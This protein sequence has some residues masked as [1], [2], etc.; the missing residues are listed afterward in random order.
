MIWKAFYAHN[1]APRTFDMKAS[2]R[3]AKR[4][5]SHLFAEGPAV[6]FGEWE[7]IVDADPDYLFQRET[8]RGGLV[9]TTLNAQDLRYHLDIP[10]GL[11]YTEYRQWF[12]HDDDIE[13]VFADNYFNIPDDRPHDR[14][15]FSSDLTDDPMPPRTYFPERSNIQDNE[16]INPAPEPMLTEQAWNQILFEFYFNIRG[17]HWTPNWTPPDIT[18]SQREFILTIASRMK[19]EKPQKRETLAMAVCR[20]IREALD[21]KS[22]GEIAEI[23]GKSRKFMYDLM[24]KFG[25]KA[26]DSPHF[27]MSENRKQAYAKRKTEHDPQR[28]AIQDLYSQGYAIDEIVEKTG[29]SRAHVG[30]ATSLMDK[31]KNCPNC[32]RNFRA[33]RVSQICCSQPCYKQYSK[34]HPNRRNRRRIRKQS[35]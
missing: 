26:S 12:S 3:G 15:V 8:P 29:F 5:A 25:L 19:I 23:G 17:G 16:N 4:Y 31:R 1:P 11:D 18:D 34:N 7:T 10:I 30:R 27:R 28:K 20:I 2:P 13:S 6:S 24:K 21:K 22:A 32:K 9:L 35:Q 33:T 14:P